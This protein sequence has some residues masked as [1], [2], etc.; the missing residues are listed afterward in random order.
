MSPAGR[1]HS[2]LSHFRRRLPR[3]RPRPPHAHCCYRHAT[4]P[5]RSE[6]LHHQRRR[7]RPHVTPTH[8]PRRCCCLPVTMVGLQATPSTPRPPHKPRHHHWRHLTPTRQPSHTRR[9]HLAPPYPHHFRHLKPTTHRRHVTSPVTPN[10]SP[11]PA[12][13]VAHALERQ[14]VSC[15]RP[16][17]SCPTHHPL[18]YLESGPSRPCASSPRQRQHQMASCCRPRSSNQFHHTGVHHIAAQMQRNYPTCSILIVPAMP[19][20]CYLL[21]PGSKPV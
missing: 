19:F 7:Q 9:L 13:V 1:H 15:R 6:R 10:L 20:L 2:V 18:C 16:H 4:S 14:M 11:A 8:P 21:V 5:L 17:S 3:P 12:C